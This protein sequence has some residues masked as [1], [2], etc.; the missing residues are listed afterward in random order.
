MSH[1][2]VSQ[3]AWEAAKSLIR[4]VARGTYGGDD[5]WDRVVKSHAR[6]WGK[7]WESEEDK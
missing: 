3:E 4:L 6:D 5:D 2:V 1:T 7:K